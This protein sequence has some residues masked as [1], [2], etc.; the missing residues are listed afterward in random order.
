M[1][2]SSPSSVGV[3]EYKAADGQTVCVEKLRECERCR[4]EF[5][6]DGQE[7]KTH[8]EN[9]YKSVT[10]PCMSCAGN[11]KP[12][13]PKWMRVCTSCYLEKKKATHGTCDFCP[14]ERRQYLSR[15]LSRPACDAC[16][17]KYFTAKV[18]PTRLQEVG[19]GE[20]EK[21]GTEAG[22]Q[23]IEGSSE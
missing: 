18:T 11:L 19:G 7:Y 6:W 15:K 8:C 5:A 4:Q 17:K 21:G 14:E 16:L 20:S 1:K 13:S 23:F 3:V 22:E 9:C 12:G 2:R 10:R